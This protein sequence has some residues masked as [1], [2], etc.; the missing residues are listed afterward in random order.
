[1][2]RLP[3]ITTR[4]LAR[5]TIPHVAEL[6]AL[7][8]TDAADAVILLQTVAEHGRPR[9]QQ[10]ALLARDAASLRALAVAALERLADLDPASSGAPAGLILACEPLSDGE[11]LR[12][13]WIAGEGGPYFALVAGC[14]E[15]GRCIIVDGRYGEEV[16]KLLCKGASALA[17]MPRG[18]LH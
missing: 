11:E 9:V 12:A 13:V 2:T 17:P 1:M 3:E 8:L 16:A 10:L 6:D 18:A 15:Q 5:R 7:L 4:L 14:P